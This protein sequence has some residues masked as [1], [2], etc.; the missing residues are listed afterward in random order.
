M[1]AQTL[2]EKIVAARQAVAKARAR[3]FAIQ[4]DTANVMAAFNDVDAAE[5][6]LD[7]LMDAD[8]AIADSAS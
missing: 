6:W 5:E 4:G 2:S 8:E 1:T 7:H 3:A